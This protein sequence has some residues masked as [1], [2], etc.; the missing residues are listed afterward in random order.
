MKPSRR[1]ESASNDCPP[2]RVGS[3]R[4]KLAATA[5]SDKLAGRVREV[6]AA[7]KIA[8]VSERR[9]FGV[10]A[11]MFDGNMLCYVSEHGLTVRLAR[12]DRAAA[13]AG[14]QGERCVV[15]DRRMPGFVLVEHAVL[16]TRSAL[17]SWLDAATDYVATL[18]LKSTRL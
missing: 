7:E 6:L 17:R 15:S 2:V 8:T 11:F 3:G 14:P 1:A 18:P 5:E 12:D 9:M 13:L 10:L 4:T 16:T